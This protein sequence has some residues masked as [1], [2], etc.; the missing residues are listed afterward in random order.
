[1]RGYVESLE[2]LQYGGNANPT[3][4][5]IMGRLADRIPERELTISEKRKLLEKILKR[6]AANEKEKNTETSS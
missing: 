4:E 5:E 1:M 2:S 3:H 6:K